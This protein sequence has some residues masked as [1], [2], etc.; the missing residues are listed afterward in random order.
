MAKRRKQSWLRSGLL[1]A[2]LYVLLVAA[3]L[4]AA[5]WTRLLNAAGIDSLLERQLLNFANLA[6]DRSMGDSIRLI[7]LDEKGNGSVGDFSDEAKRQCVRK[8]HAALLRKLK[9]AGARI[10]AF[11]LVFPPAIEACSGDSEAFATAI[12]DVQRDG[13]MR[14]VIGH[15]PA[16]DIDRLIRD[17]AG[18]A[19]LA[20]VRIGR[21]QRDA[22]NARL[23]PSILLAE[24]DEIPGQPGTVLSRPMPIALVLY[25]ADRW[26]SPDPVMPGLLPDRRT[27][28][29]TPGGSALAAISVELRNCDRG[30]L[31]CP[32]AEG[33][34]RHWYGFLPVWMGDGAAFVERSYASVVLQ[35]ALG[36]DYRDKIV[37]VGARTTD[38]IVA[39]A[40]DAKDDVTWGY[41]VHARALADLQSDTYLR[42][43]P[44]WFVAAT[45]LVLVVA[46]VAARLWLP[47]LEIKVSLPW[48]GS[49]PIPIGLILVAVMFGG[50]VILLMRQQYWLQDP[51]YQ[52]IALAAGY[53][54]ASRPLLP[55][56]ATHEGKAG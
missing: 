45:L 6:V 27:V 5:N 13:S 36:E 30:E 32:L 29:F 4:S 38:E 33:A 18:E 42:R 25:L 15:D 1:R 20:L 23:L 7:Y 39:R 16:S 3:I 11:D 48:I 26:R 8:H 12:H 14:V 44:F 19:N 49:M 35:A 46:G 10:V 37:I 21:E 2:S 28:V 22:E 9:L 53:Y 31:N 24:A 51:G 40:R 54:F 52:L 17:R 43:P 56:P 55:A 50:V 41:Q 34:S 47:R